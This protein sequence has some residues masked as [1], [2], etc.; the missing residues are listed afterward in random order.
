MKITD[1]LMRSVDKLHS[2]VSKAV[3]GDLPG[4]EFHGNQWTEEQ[5]GR[6]LELGFK[7]GQEADDES[8]GNFLDSL[9]DNATA[10]EEEVG[11]ALTRKDLYRN[12]IKEDDGKIIGAVAYAVSRGIASIHHMGSL[13]KG[14]GRRM[15]NKLKNNYYKII[16][17]DV[18]DEARGFY[19]NQGFRNSRFGD[20]NDMVWE[21]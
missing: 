6:G 8:V 21:R 16:A 12:I 17:K 2:I 10:S 19:E 7:P 11:N 20:S 4:H 5:G 3:K 15:M 13:Q 9:S 1:K 18:R 14:I